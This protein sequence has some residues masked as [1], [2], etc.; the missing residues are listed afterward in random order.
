MCSKKNKF[1]KSYAP[2]NAMSLDK[3]QLI[4]QEVEENGGT[5][6][7]VP[8]GVFQTVAAKFKMHRNSVR[9]IW[10]KYK[11]DGNQNRRQ[12]RGR[13]SGSE[14]LTPQDFEFT[15]RPSGDRFKIANLRYTQAYL[16]Y[17]VQQ[18][19]RKLKFFDESGVKV[20][21]ANKS[22]GHSQIGKPCVEIERYQEGAILTL[23][24]LVGSD[25]VKHF[26]FVDGASNSAF[27]INFFHEAIEIVSDDGYPV[28][29][30]GDIVVVDNAA[31]HH[32]HAEIILSNYFSD[33]NIHY[34]FLPTYSPDK[35]P[36]EPCFGKIK[37]CLQN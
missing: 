23:N 12:K 34:I 6:F 29:S 27:Y 9:R 1:R 11:E 36:A 2:G 4:I 37:R 32:N 19:V 15:E 3:R 5:E 21:T 25:G 31:F 26:N 28:L 8:R 14:K 13:L 17:I 33:Q 16:D 22:R 30:P 7:A 18:D 10:L 35:N 24:L 20:T